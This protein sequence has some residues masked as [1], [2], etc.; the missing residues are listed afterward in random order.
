FTVIAERERCP[1]AVVG[2]VTAEQQLH[3]FDTHFNEAVVDLP[4]AL[5]FG[6]TPKRVREVRSDYVEQS[7]LYWSSIDLAEAAERVLQLPCVADK[8]FLI[9]IADRSV[10]GMVVRDQM[11]GPW[12]VPVADVAVT[13]SNF[14]GYTGEAMAM[15][16]RAPIALIHPAASA[17]M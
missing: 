9:T 14:T 1:F 13:A 15:G 3:V 6:N 2:E 11:V 7:K 17:R 4:L 8:S 10:G 16:E 5:L 12:Q